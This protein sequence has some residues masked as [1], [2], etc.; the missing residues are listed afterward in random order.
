LKVIAGT[1][2]FISTQ[3]IVVQNEAIWVGS[4]NSNFN[5]TANWLCSYPSD[6]SDI[7]IKGNTAFPLTINNTNIRIKNLII[8]SNAVLV[9][10]NSNITISGKLV[11]N[12]HISNQS[13]TFIFSGSAKQIIEGNLKADKLIIDNSAGVE[14][15]NSAQDSVSVYEVLTLKQGAFLPTIN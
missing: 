15:G 7:V 10:N 6:T 3:K 1:N 11:S 13:S 8:D 4:T 14:I 9:I 12:G 2:L 5:D